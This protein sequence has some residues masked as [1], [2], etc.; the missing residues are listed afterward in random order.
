MNLFVWQ[1]LKEAMEIKRVLLSLIFA[2]GMIGAQGLTVTRPEIPPGHTVPEGLVTSIGAQISIPFMPRIGE[3]FEVTFTVSCKNDLDRIRFGP[4][5][6]VI[7]TSNAASII[8]GKE[9]RFS[10]YMK[11]GEIRQFKARMVI[12]EPSPTVSIKAAISAPV[13]GPQGVG[14]L[15]FLTD[16]KTGQY[17][18]KD[19]WLRKAANVFWKYNHLDAQW[20]SEPDPKL[21]ASNRQIAVEMKKFEPALTDSEALCLHQ[22]NYFLI[23][24]A[25]GDS[26]ATDSERV[27]HLLKAGWLEAQRA[28][29]KAKEKWLNDFMEENQRR[30]A[31]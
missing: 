23:I 30:W 25:I 29:A 20:L 26:C 6:T 28:G 8:S 22:D 21:E 2:M 4:D 13:W 16:E 9:Q 12:N 31:K 3:I 10:G 24:N 5:Y 27:E 17:D 15:L 1:S 7:F 18:T 19:K 11:R 14:F